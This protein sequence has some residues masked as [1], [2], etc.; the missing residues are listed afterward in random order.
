MAYG[1]AVLGEGVNITAGA[2]V[3]MLLFAAVAIYGVVLLSRF[4]PGADADAPPT[5]VASISD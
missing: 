2:A 1:I 4:H 3:L 5:T